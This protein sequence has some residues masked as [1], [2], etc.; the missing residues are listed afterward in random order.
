[1]PLLPCRLVF[2]RDELII[3]TMTEFHQPISERRNCPVVLVHVFGFFFAFTQWSRGLLPSSQVFSSGIANR[4][5][6]VAFM[7]ST[8]TAHPFVQI[9]PLWEAMEEIR[10]AAKSSS[11]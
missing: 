10:R 6:P 2:G 3:S 8:G 7:V 9:I 11:H 5:F 4:I 1:M